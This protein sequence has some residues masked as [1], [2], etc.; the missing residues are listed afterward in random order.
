VR[1]AQNPTNAL[2]FGSLNP[3]YMKMAKILLK[4]PGFYETVQVLNTNVAA[5]QRAVPPV[6]NSFPFVV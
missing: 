6:A 4:K 5:A 3:T 2:G 1:V